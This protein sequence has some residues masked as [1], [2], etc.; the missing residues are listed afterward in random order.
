[1]GFVA[2]ML[3]R[4]HYLIPENAVREGI[5]DTVLSAREKVKSRV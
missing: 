3:D 1:M 4:D 5:I 2:R